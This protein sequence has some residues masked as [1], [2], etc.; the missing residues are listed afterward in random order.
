MSKP[1]TLLIGKRFSKTDHIS[2]GESCGL[3]REVIIGPNMIRKID[4]LRVKGD[5][6]DGH[7]HAVGHNMQCIKGPITVTTAKVMEEDGTYTPVESPTTT[8]L[9]NG[10]V[11]FIP[12]MVGH[13]IA[14]E[15][16]NAEFW[17]WFAHR[18]G[19]GR[20]VDYP[21]RNLAAYY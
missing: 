14:A 11:L 12:A 9:N 2:V 1:E 21:V 17:C 20:V 7:C 15:T 6:I 3:G 19:M 16:D 4:N 5:V 18:D 8:M 10:D 13:T